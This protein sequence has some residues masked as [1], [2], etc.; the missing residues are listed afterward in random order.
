MSHS[1]NRPRTCYRRLQFEGALPNARLNSLSQIYKEGEHNTLMLH[2]WTKVI[3][4]NTL[5]HDV[6]SG[7]L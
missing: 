1:V 2:D 5:Q 4:H 6:L 7:W 3:A